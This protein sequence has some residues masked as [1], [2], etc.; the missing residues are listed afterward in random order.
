MNHEMTFEGIR[1]YANPAIPNAYYFLPETPVP[2]TDSNGDPMLSLI[3]AGAHWFLQLGTKWQA[4]TDKLEKLQE[5]LA[6]AHRA[7]TP[8]LLSIAPVAIEKA[9][10]ILHTQDSDKVLAS[11]GSSGSYP[12]TT[13]LNATI[14]SDLQQEVVSAIHGKPHV[15]LVHYHVL[16]QLEKTVAMELSG[17]IQ[18]A[19][20]TLHAGS[21][22][23]AVR[24]WIET[25]IHN[26]R[27]VM[28]ATHDQDIPA[29]LLDNTRNKLLNTATEEVLR[30]LRGP[31]HKLDSSGME[32]K[33]TESHTIPEKMLVSTD[34]GTWFSGNEGNDHIKILA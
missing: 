5:K 21:P 29:E 7:Q 33:V 30:F 11:S 1:Y 9:E 8:I 3:G 14:S 6:V 26:G 18:K 32:V 12:Y 22:P 31:G 10:L 27:L 25:E 28:R 34:I 4:P 2:Q 19:R 15:L 23:E 17:P 13:A 16:H 20:Q 24:E